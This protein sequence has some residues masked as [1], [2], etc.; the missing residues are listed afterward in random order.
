MKITI[1]ITP[2]EL[3]DI[4]NV[5]TNN[6]RIPEHHNVESDFC[7]NYMPIDT[8][9]LFSLLGVEEE[10]DEEDDRV[11]EDKF[12]V[13]M[14]LDEYLAVNTLHSANRNVN[15]PSKPN[16]MEILNFIINGK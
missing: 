5:T 6:E 4:I 2:K 15:K 16:D 1:D 13:S 12:N 3:L 10:Q 7:K 11:E 9:T 8:S 14:S